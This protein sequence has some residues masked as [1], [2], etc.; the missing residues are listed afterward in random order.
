MVLVN[1]FHL[2]KLRGFVSNKKKNLPSGLV[3]RSQTR[4]DTGNDTSTL[5][6]KINEDNHLED[7]ELN[8]SQDNREFDY[9]YLTISSELVEENDID[10]AFSMQT[11]TIPN[12]TNEALEDPTW[13]ES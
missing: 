2:G 9:D 6:Y 4:R 7:S 5:V 12:S 11:L 10:I 1:K 3:T 13:K 8:L